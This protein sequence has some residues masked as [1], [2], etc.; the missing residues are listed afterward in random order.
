MKHLTTITSPV[1]A[2]ILDGTAHDSI[3]E[4]IYTLFTTP[5]ANWLTYVKEHINLPTA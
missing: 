3:L 5:V 1:K 2:D 4:I